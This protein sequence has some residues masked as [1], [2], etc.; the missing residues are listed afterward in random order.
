MRV[1]MTGATSDTGRRLCGRLL[2]AG[3][4]VVCFTRGRRPIPEGAEAVRGDLPEPG[5]PWGEGEK[6]LVR[7][8]EG[9]ALVHCCTH[10]RFAPAVVE[11]ALAAGVVR[12][13]CVS[14]ARRFTRWPAENER[15]VIAAEE[16]LMQR[17]E[18]WVALRST[19]IYGGGSDKNI[20]RLVRAVK[21]WPLVV[22]PGDGRAR[23]QPLFVEDLVETLLAADHAPGAHGKIIN[24]AGP[25]P[26]PL[27]EA[28]E[29]IARVLGRRR[30]L[31][32]VPLGP[33]RIAASLGGARSRDRI[34]R[35]GEDRVL[36]IAEA[37]ELLGFAP[38]SFEEGLRAML[39][40]AH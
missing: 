12:T 17:P 9:C 13:V 34:R 8:L 33:A 25:E 40:T 20:A 28:V 6:A 37:R 10:I 31:V 26:M 21:R 4:H 29:I 2:A 16:A 1:L 23:I 11:R 19:M 3:H 14:S 36:D 7:A 39:E 35:M 38:R 5:Q 27:R 22:L 32:P 18:G 15:R 30:L 24:V